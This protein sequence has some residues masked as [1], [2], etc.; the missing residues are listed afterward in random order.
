MSNRWKPQMDKQPFAALG[1]EGMI[2]A[3]RTLVEECS[4]S[5]EEYG[6]Y[7]EAKRLLAAHRSEMKL[8]E[9][10]AEN[11]PPFKMTAEL[12]AEIQRHSR[13]SFH[14]RRAQA[15]ST[16]MK[17]CCAYITKKRPFGCSLG[18]SILVHAILLIAVIIGFTLSEKVNPSDSE[19]NTPTTVFLIDEPEALPKLK[20][21]T[22][23][24]R[25]VWR[26]WRQESPSFTVAV[27]NP[28]GQFDETKQFTY[29]PP[30][31]ITAINPAHGSVAGSDTI[32]ITGESFAD[33]PKVM[34]GSTPATHIERVSSRELHVITPKG[35]AGS[36]DVVVTNP[37]G[38]RTTSPFTYVRSTVV[39]SSIEPP[40]GSVAGGQLL[41][42]R[43]ENFGENVTVSIG[44]KEATV[45]EYI[46]ASAIRV[47]TP[48][49]T[50]GRA[51]IVVTN[52]DAEQGTLP[53]GFRY[54][55]PT[56]IAITGMNPQSIQ[57]R[58][59]IRIAGQISP[60]V[61]TAVT[62]TFTHEK[63]SVNESIVSNDNG[64][65]LSTLSVDQPGEWEV[66]ARWAG[67]EN[68]LGAES[69]TITFTVQKKQPHI[70]VETNP[71]QLTVGE[72]VSI[73]GWVSPN[74]GIVD[75]EVVTRKSGGSEGLVTT[76]QIQTDHSGG[77]DF[78]FT[79]H[80]AGDWIVEVHFENTST[81]L[82][83]SVNGSTALGR[84]IIVAG[85]SS[86]AEYNALWETTRYLT[87]LAYKTLR[88]RG[89]S[90]QMIQYLSPEPFEE[91]DRDGRNDVTGAS[92]AENLR[93]AIT[94][95][96]DFFQKNPPAQLFL[97]FTGHSLPD[98]LRLGEE[99]E[100]VTSPEL[101]Q[102]LDTLQEQTGLKEVIVVLDAC[103][104]GSFID[105]LA[106]EGRTIITSTDSEGLALFRGDGYSSFSQF[107]FE[108]VSSG[109]PVSESFHAAQEEM[110]A[111]RPLHYLRPQID[112]DGNG[113][114][115]Q[116]TDMAIANRL[117]IG[118]R[119]LPETL[120]H[121]IPD[122]TKLLPN[123]PNPSNPETWIPYRLAE[124]A[125]VTL[126]IYDMTGKVVR[127]LEIGHQRAAIYESRD[128]A[129]YW[130][131]RNNFGEQVASG[132]YFY[133]LTAGDFSATR[134]IVILK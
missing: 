55:N 52:T 1:D 106:Q 18:I 21:P 89:Y 59:Q 77:Y 123:F 47:R 118:Q 34:I 88:E 10:E 119:G 40:A 99:S 4:V 103:Y 50:L 70:I 111:S 83:I 20:M 71:S 44:G 12:R 61:A 96:V 65:F 2:E 48:P 125:F 124:D 24:M 33:A 69:E 115:N 14:A 15:A 78:R 73:R 53:G 45:V 134:K 94:G 25:T 75:L 98:R 58:G 93:E 51:D 102:W 131:G 9:A 112:S 39:V 122:E 22:N 87:N 7:L 132:I 104:S 5:R 3:E 91:P 110:L 133:R 27:E 62:L 74:P 32:T 68:Y 31:F 36:V 81:R 120:K 84:A 13:P 46:S 82:I 95:T 121:E 130:D 60:P 23:Q 64:E 19:R 79:P 76:T 113:T 29:N 26:H 107:F 43:G 114:P 128:K 80:Q 127:T 35:D 54:K 86:R 72:P 63:E 11:V 66:I 108:H 90:R 67:N 105:D 109:Q 56:Q 116:E 97:Y 57:E 100:V 49:D 101:A 129:V 16:P 42:I 41:L 38:Q 28:D 126:T 85:G 37:D 92:T 8:F 117:Y 30:P 17:A 6:H